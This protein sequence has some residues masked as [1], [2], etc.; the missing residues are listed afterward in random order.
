[1]TTSPTT[2]DLPRRGF[3]LI[4]L[5]VVLILIGLTLTLALPRY[6][7]FLIRG[8]MRS[9]ARRISALARYLSCEASRTGRT[10][11]IDFEVGKDEYRVTVDAGGHRA[12]EAAGALAE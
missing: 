6:G 10:H 11:Y 7:G 12:K 5:C 2:N 3:T 9:D 8:G 1:M 4:E